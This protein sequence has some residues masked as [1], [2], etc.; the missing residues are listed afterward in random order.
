MIESIIKKIVNF[1]KTIF[2]KDEE[3]G[4]LQNVEKIAKLVNFSNTIFFSDRVW[5]LYEDDWQGPSS[6]ILRQRDSDLINKIYT[7]CKDTNIN[8][9]VCVHGILFINLKDNDSKFIKIKNCKQIYLSLKYY[10]NEEEYQYDLRF[11][12]E[13]DVVCSKLLLEQEKKSGL[14]I[15]SNFQSNHKFLET[16]EK[17]SHFDVCR[18]KIDC[19]TEAFPTDCYYMIFKNENFNFVSQIC[20]D[21][22]ILPWSYS[23]FTKN[24]TV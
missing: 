10:P 13:R 12:K 24:N 9:L 6:F 15:I 1:F 23:S 4:F 14:S 7:I 18:M 16:Q 2:V 5:I 20:Q 22:V 21:L 19:N 8:L 11:K 3:Q 17:Y